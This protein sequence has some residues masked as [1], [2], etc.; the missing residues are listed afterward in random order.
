L[1]RLSPTTR[2]KK[3]GAEELVLR[4]FATKNARHLFKGSVRDWLDNY[5]EQVLLGQEAFNYARE[6]SIFHDVFSLA[7]TKL[8]DTAFL[9]YREHSPVGSLPPAYFEAISIGIFN[10]RNEIKDKDHQA[11]RNAITSLV[12]SDQFRAVTG[13]GA[14]SKEKLETRINLATDALRNV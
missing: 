5:M 10:T 3:K 8:G 2:K 4:F 7:R 6:E 14:N 11:L 12:Q 9:R 13:P 1:L